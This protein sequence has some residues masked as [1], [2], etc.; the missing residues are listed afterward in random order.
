ML[1]SPRDDDRLARRRRVAATWR[2]Q[3]G[4]PRQL[5]LVVV[6]VRAPDRSAR[7]PT[8]TRI[9]AAGGGDQRGPRDRAASPSAKPATHVVDADPRQDRHAVPLALA[10][11]GGRVAERLERQGREGRRRRSFVSCMQ[12]MS[13]C[14]S[15]SHASTRGC[16]TCSELMF[17][18]ASRITPT[19]RPTPHRSGRDAPSSGV[20]LAGAFAAGCRGGSAVRRPALSVPALEPSVAGARCAARPL[21]SCGCRPWRGF[22]AGAAARRSTSTGGACVG[23]RRLDLALRGGRLLGRRPLGRCGAARRLGGR[24]PAV[25]GRSSPPI[26]GRAGLLAR[27]AWPARGSAAARPRLGGASSAAGSAAPRPSCGVPLGRLPAPGAAASALD[28]GPAP[29]PARRGRCSDAVALKLT[30]TSVDRVAELHRPRARC[31]AAARPSAAAARSP[32]TSPIVT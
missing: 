11:V 13:G 12:T 21:P 9:A 17:Q 19:L 5:V 7:R 27:S 24:R 25:G 3:P 14:T 32:R 26:R 18:V 2:A 15:A 30:T 31:G 1:K 29:C 20:R 8:T 6:V 4:Q 28:L 16:R 23:R 10:V 22:L